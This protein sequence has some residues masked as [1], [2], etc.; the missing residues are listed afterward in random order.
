VDPEPSLAGDL[1][2]LGERVSQALDLVRRLRAENERLREQVAQAE[3]GD[4]SSAATGEEVRQKLV[5]L[6][7]RLEE[8]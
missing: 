2:L 1:E 3:V 8:F 7:Q 6:L 4:R 5:A